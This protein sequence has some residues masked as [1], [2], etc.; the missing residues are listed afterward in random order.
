MYQIDSFIFVSLRDKS[1]YVFSAPT[2]LILQFLSFHLFDFKSKILNV[3]FTLRKNITRITQLLSFI[4]FKGT[5]LIL[6]EI[7]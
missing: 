3:M 7:G 6:G 4:P 2:N 1:F 5:K